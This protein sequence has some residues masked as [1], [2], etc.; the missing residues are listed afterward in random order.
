MD[1]PHRGHCTGFFLTGTPTRRCENVIEI[2]NA[3]A[4]CYPRTASWR[5]RR[6]SMRCRNECSRTLRESEALLADENLDLNAY[7]YGRL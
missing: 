1:P 3:Q 4:Q 5:L 7:L 6:G 2:L